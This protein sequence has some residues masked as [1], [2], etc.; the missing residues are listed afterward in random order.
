VLL[1][2]E[3]TGEIKTKESGAN[4]LLTYKP[5]KLLYNPVFVWTFFKQGFS[6]NHLIS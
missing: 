1:G 6:L 5:Y 3:A 2:K 4:L